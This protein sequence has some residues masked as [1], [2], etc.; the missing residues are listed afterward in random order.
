[1]RQIAHCG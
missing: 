1:M